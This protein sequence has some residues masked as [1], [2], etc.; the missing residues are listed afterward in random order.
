MKLRTPIGY[1]AAVCYGYILQSA[2][3]YAMKFASPDDVRAFLRDHAEIL[4][5]GVELVA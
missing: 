4:P 5:F 1:I 2:E 3:D